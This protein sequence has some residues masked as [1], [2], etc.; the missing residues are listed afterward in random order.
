MC[1]PEQSFRNSSP[2]C[3][4]AWLELSL[5]GGGRIHEI[6]YSSLE[7]CV[8]ALQ[9]N[10]D[11]ATAWAQLGIRGGGFVKLN[12]P[13]WDLN[14]GQ[15]RESVECLLGVRIRPITTYFQRQFPFS[16][17]WFHFSF[18]PDMAFTVGH[19]GST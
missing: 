15:F 17:V 19:D 12:G 11:S 3:S 16:H 13:K 14:G 8:Q 5:L 9:R 1:P 4:E 18:T 7:C 6:P 10:S 2:D